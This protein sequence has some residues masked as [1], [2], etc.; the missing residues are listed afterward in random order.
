MPPVLLLYGVWRHLVLDTQKELPGPAGYAVVQKIAQN[1]SWQSLPCINSIGV[2][3]RRHRAGE[4]CF[5]THS[6][7]LWELYGS[8]K[9]ES[10][11]YNKSYL[12][13]VVLLV[14]QNSPSG[15]Q[16]RFVWEAQSKLGIFP[17]RKCVCF[18]QTSVGK[19]DKQHCD[20]L[21]TRIR[22]N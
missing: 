20:P 14:Q 12:Y 21:G 7:C 4:S 9:F 8:C 3:L 16:I 17:S 6:L 18:E 22:A 1:G 15:A 19:I 2:W 10:A 5:D 13:I 11:V